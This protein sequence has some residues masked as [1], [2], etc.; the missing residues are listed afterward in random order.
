M[1]EKILKFRQ[2]RENLNQ[3]LLSKENNADILKRI[4]AADTYSYQERNKGL[5]AKQKEIVGLA[6]S[7]VL[8]C[9][10]CIKYHLEKCHEL[11]VNNDEMM[12]VFGLANLVGGTIVIPH[13]RRA[14]EYWEILNQ[15]RPSP[16][17]FS[18]ETKVKNYEQITK[19][20]KSLL[21]GVDNDIAKM[22]S[23]NEV[24]KNNISYFDWV[25]F[26]L[27]DKDKLVVGPYQGK[28]GCLY[29][30]N[31]EGVCG[32]AFK[33]QE[34]II[35]EDL[36]KLNNQQDISG[37]ILHIACDP[38]SKSEIV[39]PVFKNGEIIGVFDIDSFHKKA[40]DKIDQKYL[41]KILSWF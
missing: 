27:W 35:V 31:G 19:Q 1:N 37:K 40:F 41:E 15:D 33:Q 34:T 8:R 9:D 13:S 24:L 14:I 11:G 38:N 30:K 16:S 21:A 12:D 7:M 5:S 6:T 26:Y 3:K 18:E 2:E 32:R 20:I 17:P 4:F 10:D 36:H 25:G 28:H 23:I 29:I 22:A 39:L